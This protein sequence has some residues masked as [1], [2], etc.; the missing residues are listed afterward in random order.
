MDSKLNNH[1]AALLWLG[2]VMLSL[3]LVLLLAGVNEGPCLYDDG[4][5]DGLIAAGVVLDSLGTILLAGWLVAGAVCWQIRNPRK[6][7]R[8]ASSSATSHA[9]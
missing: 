7:G 1:L 3:G 9:P 2:C 8:L 6:S 5:G 4:A